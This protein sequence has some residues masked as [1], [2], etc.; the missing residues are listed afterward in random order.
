MNGVFEGVDVVVCAGVQGR[1][2]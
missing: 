2:G 1:L